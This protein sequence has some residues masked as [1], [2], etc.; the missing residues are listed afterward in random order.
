MARAKGASC[1]G[2]A[3]GSPGAMGGGGR[4][5]PP[6]GS[7]VPGNSSDGPGRDLFGG[8]RDD[9]EGGSRGDDDVFQRGAA[10][11]LSFPL[12][13][14]SFVFGDSDCNADMEVIHVSHFVTT[15][16]ETGSDS[17]ANSGMLCDHNFVLLRHRL[18]LNWWVLHDPD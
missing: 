5:T 12:A 8:R 11:P 18:C 7:D 2:A 14:F 4:E 17:Y 3:V 16:N 13:V 15:D 9:P 10:R 6:R 1:V